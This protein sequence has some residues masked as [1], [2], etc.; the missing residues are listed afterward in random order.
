MVG[1][2]VGFVPRVSL[3]FAMDWI[4]HYR[5]VARRACVVDCDS[6][7]LWFTREGFERAELSEG[8]F[9]EP[10][11]PHLE[12]FIDEPPASGERV[13]FPGSNVHS[14]LIDAYANTAFK[15]LGPRPFT[16]RV[17]QINQALPSY[18]DRFQGAA[19]ITAYNPYSDALTDDVNRRRHAVLREYLEEKGMEFCDGEGGDDAGEWPPEA[20]YYLSNISLF[21]ATKI[22]KQWG[23]NAIVWASNDQIPRLIML[24]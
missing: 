23:Q 20:S 13:P 8:K 19:F 12:I 14:S 6:N 18:S 9:L 5:H 3:E 7:R 2:H 4:E 24:R 21:E 17:G 10:P 22:G 16:L 1:E 15:V 11:V